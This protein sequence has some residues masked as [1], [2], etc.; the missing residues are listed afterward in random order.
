MTFGNDS[1]SSA[2]DGPPFFG[3]VR[4]ANGSAVAGAKVTATVKSGGA[5]VTRSNSMGVYKIPG[6]AKDIDPK[7]VTISCA[8]DGYK[9][10]NIL[11]RPPS[12]PKDPIEVE[13]NLQKE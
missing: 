8:R 4:D 2:N 7:D 13:C 9:Q 6:F 1:N 11:R 10:A 5:I 3:F 12:D